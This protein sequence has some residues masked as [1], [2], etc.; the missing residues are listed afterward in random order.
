MNDFRTRKSNTKPWTQSWAFL[1]FLL[2][3]L[4]FFA[5]SAYT[6]FA[7]KRNADAE[8]IKYEERLNELILKK[9]SLEER[10]ENLNTE[11]GVEEELRKRF[12]IVKPG[13]TLIRIIEKPEVDE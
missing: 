12:N 6:S 4:G 7:K 13:E 1:L 9:E 11:R 3:I 5:R 10:I 2:F 8:R